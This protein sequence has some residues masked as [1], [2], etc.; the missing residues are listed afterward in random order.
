MKVCLAQINTTPGDFDGNLRAIKQ[1]I[2]AGSAGAADLVVFPELTIPGYLS[3]DLIYQPKF[4]DRNL[5]VLQEVIDYSADLSPSLHIVVGCIELNES[6]GKPYFNVAIVIAAGRI[7]GRYIKQLLPFYD[8]FDELRYFEAGNELLVLEIAGSKVGFT[9]CEDLWNDKGSDDY[10]YADNPMEMYRQAGVTTIV[11]LNSSPFVE[12]KPWNRLNMIAPGSEPD[13]TVVYVN[14]RGGQD[15]LVFDGQS[16]V[17]RNGDLLHLCEALFEDSFD[18]VDISRVKPIESKV[19]KLEHREHRSPNLKDLLVLCLRDYV[20]KSGFSK[21][22]LASSGGVD[23]AVVCKLACEAVGPE[24]VHAIRMPSKF[25]SLHSREDAIKLHENLGCWDYEME[26]DHE[27]TVQLL[28][29]RY[30]SSATMM[31][32]DGPINTKLTA[33]DYNSI[34]DENIQARMRDL[35]VMHFS[36]AFGAMPLSTGNK[37]ESACGYYTHFDMNFSFAPIKDLYKYQV[38]DIAKA[39]KDIPDNI[40]Q[41]PPSA[42]LA[43]GQTDEESLLPYAILDPIVRAYVEDY[44]STYAEFSIWLH[45]HLKAKAKIS[46]DI[47]VLRQWSE[48][49]IQAQ[50][51]FEKISGLIGRMEFKRRQTCPGTKVSK[52]AFGIGRRIPIVEKWS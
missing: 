20:V 49:P 27:P 17:V 46:M 10:N 38:V 43:H 34:A 8:V 6:V 51:D 15:E 30:R 40:W 39:F 42:E 21:L 36:N 47:D 32:E 26:I 28:N 4:I 1:G 11:S 37:T 9:I 23:S 45:R 29:E 44:V 48:Q 33:G 52:V 31:L 2:D 24:N 25:S 13:I 5:E 50:K 3:Q 41:K 14:Q 16:F 12:G 18:L 7:V 22:V 35:Y 19:Y